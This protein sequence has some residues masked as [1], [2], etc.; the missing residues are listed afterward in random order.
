[1]NLRLHT[2]NLFDLA[3]AAEAA[4]RSSS[5]QSKG[6]NLLSTRMGSAPCTLSGWDVLNG[7]G[8]KEVVHNQE[9][10]LSSGTV[11]IGNNGGNKSVVH[12]LNLPFVEKI[13]PYTTWIFLNKY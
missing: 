2:C 5:N 1:M 6:E 13:P 3:A 9:E 7:S 8:D 4:T 10:V 12:L 11:V